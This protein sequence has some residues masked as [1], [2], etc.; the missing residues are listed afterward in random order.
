[1]RVAALLLAGGVGIATAQA[2]SGGTRVEFLPM[3]NTLPLL[4]F[5]PDSLAGTMLEPLAMPKAAAEAPAAE[6]LAAIPDEAA[7]EVPP[8][9]PAMAEGDTEPIEEP[10]AK[11]ATA[12]AV[13]A[14]DPE[15]AEMAPVEEPDTAEVAPLEEPESPA[16]ESA[17]V[18]HVIVENVESSSGTVN[19]AVCDTDFTPEGCPYKVSVRATAGFVEAQF[20]DVPPGSYAVV[21]YHD[22]NDNDEFDKFLGVPREPY[23]LSGSAANEMVPEFSDAVLDINQGENYVII[24]M[25]RLGSG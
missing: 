24:R 21:G 2:Q 17:T 10:P 1:M 3:P 8:L 14:G 15:T 25:K 5:A 19:V 22:V 16:S 23:A 12:E 13:P 6:R 11:I 18:V 20:D 9:R 7:P 4:F